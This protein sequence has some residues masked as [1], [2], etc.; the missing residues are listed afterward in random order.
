MKGFVN[1]FLEYKIDIKKRCRYNHRG[2]I[3][4][5]GDTMQKYFIA[6]Q[7]T[8][9]MFC[10]IPFPCKKWDESCRPYMLFFLPLIGL[11]IGIL[12][13]GLDFLLNYLGING[14]IYGIVMCAWPY[15]STGFMHLDGFMDVTDAICSWRS[16]EKRRMIL[17]DSHVGS[18][19]VVWCIFLILADFSLFA[20]IPSKSG[21]FCLLFI[22]VLSRCCSALAIMKLKVMNTSQYAQTTLYP[23]WHKI[24]LVFLIAACVAGS[25]LSSVKN[26][27]VLLMELLGYAFFLKKSYTSLDGMN[28]D[29][30][31]FCICISELCAV[32]AFALL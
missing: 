25:F 14:F 30:S 21:S 18:F 4:F 9:S 32:A 1:F 29:I 10:W 23:E 3:T 7:M 12:W 27:L 31:G 20:S 8:Q 22:P 28:G 13:A 17:K 2:K 26:G 11:E 16:L 5:R 24:F 15:L 6:F 19:A